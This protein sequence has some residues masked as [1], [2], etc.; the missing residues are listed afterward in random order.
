MPH[1]QYVVSLIALLVVLTA[2]DRQ[3]GHAAGLSETGFG[4]AGKALIAATAVPLALPATLYRPRVG[5]GRT[6]H[7]ARGHFHLRHGWRVVLTVE[8]R[9]AAGEQLLRA[10][11]GEGHEL[12]GVQM[13]WSAHHDT[14]LSFVERVR[15]GLVATGDGTGSSRQGHGEE[16]ARLREAQNSCRYL[17]TCGRPRVDNS[18]PRYSA[19]GATCID[20]CLI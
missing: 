7:A 1:R 10:E 18:R 5:V 6:R 19:R 13:H 2:A 9:R 3:N 15:V 20:R 8:A 4:A 11:R 16:P 17:S 14:P 12:V